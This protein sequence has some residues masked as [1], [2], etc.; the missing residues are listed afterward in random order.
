MYTQ[1]NYLA[2]CSPVLFTVYEREL[3]FEIDSEEKR[4]FVPNSMMKISVNR[5]N[6]YPEHL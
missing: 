4:P 6:A 5:C 3:A 2:L 1:R